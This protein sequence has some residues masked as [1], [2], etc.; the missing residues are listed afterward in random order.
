M[1]ATAI[2]LVEFGSFPAMV[3]CSDQ[4]GRRWFRRGPDVRGV[5]WPHDRVNPRTIAYDI[6]RDNAPAPGSVDVG[7]D[8]WFAHRD[9]PRYAVRE[10][11]IRIANDLVLSLIWWRDERQLLNLEDEDHEEP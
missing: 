6:L 2:R 1:T 11:S 4:E 7:A 9:A 3:V 10:D 8:G 5:L